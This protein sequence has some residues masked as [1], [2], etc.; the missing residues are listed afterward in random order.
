MQGGVNTVGERSEPEACEGAAGAGGTPDKRSAVQCEGGNRNPPSCVLVNP[1]AACRAV[2]PYGQPPRPAPPSTPPLEGNGT[3]AR[4]APHLIRRCAPPARRVSAANL[5]QWSAAKLRNTGL[6]QRRTVR[7][8][9]R[10]RQAQ[11]LHGKMQNTMQKAAR[12]KRPTAPDPLH[13]N[14]GN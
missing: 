5:T 10:G 8:L 9:S 13:N 3:G 11:R 7:R 4:S 2:A 1:K 6:S 14:Y 12:P